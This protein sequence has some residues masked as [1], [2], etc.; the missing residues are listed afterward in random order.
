MHICFL[1]P[2]IDCSLEMT[3]TPHGESSERRFFAEL[4]M[5]ILLLAL[6]RAKL[7]DNA[8]FFSLT[9]Q[10]PFVDA[11]AL[12]SDRSSGM[13]LSCRNTHF[14]AE[15][16]SLSIRKTSRCIPEYVCGRESS[17]ERSCVVFGRGNDGIR[18]MRR[19]SVDVL[20][21]G[22]D[23]RDDLDSHFWAEVFR[24]EGFGSGGMN[25]F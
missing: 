5:R 14:R 6:T 22:A 8:S 4:L 24:V 1:Q 2:S 3:I 11:Q 20:D 15:T 9:P 18:V 23:G 13:R 25:Q 17:D 19:M 10:D 7:S 21:G 12:Q 16:V